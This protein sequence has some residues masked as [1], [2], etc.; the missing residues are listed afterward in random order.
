[1]SDLII[2][3]ELLA[4]CTVTA[5]LRRVGPGMEWNTFLRNISA[6]S[7]ITEIVDLNGNSAVVGHSH[8]LSRLQEYIKTFAKR[9]YELAELGAIRH[10]PLPTAGQASGR[11]KRQ[12]SSADQY[13]FITIEAQPAL[14]GASIELA[15]PDNESVAREVQEPHLAEAIFDGICMAA[16]VQHHRPVVCFCVKVLAAKWHPIDSH[17]GAFKKVACDAMAEIISQPL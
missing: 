2:R 16:L 7:L 14:S 17:A 13:A 4:Q 3:R 1:M 10:K 6:Q 9:S 15:I 12:G 11:L 5:I 8:D